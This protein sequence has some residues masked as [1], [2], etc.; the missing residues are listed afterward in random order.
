M[1]LKIAIA[2][3]DQPLESITISRMED[4]KGTNRWHEYMVQVETEP[5]G[6]AFFSHLY[7]EGAQ[8]CLRKALDALARKR[9]AL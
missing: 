5:E 9:G 6:Y 2:V 4:F 8:T 3:N 7:S 1:P